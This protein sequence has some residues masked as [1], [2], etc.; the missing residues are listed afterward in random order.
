MN[1]Q[2]VRISTYAKMKDVSKEIV[3]LWVI[4]KKV[5]SK[6]IDKTIFIILED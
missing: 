3:R 2:L 1:E 5:K 4:N 6:V